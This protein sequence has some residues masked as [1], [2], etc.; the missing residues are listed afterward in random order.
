M[1][2]NNGDGRL[3]AGTRTEERPHPS[4]G[5][6]PYGDDMREQ[7]IEMWLDGGM[8][9]LNAPHLL[10]LRHAKKFPSLPKCKRWIEQ[11]QEEG[12]VRPK[13]ATGNHIA[14]REIE[15]IDLF[16]LGIY[17]QVRPKAYIDEVRAF[18]HNM[19][20]TV[21]PYS[22]SQVVRAEQRLGLS[23]KAASTTSECA[24]IPINLT[25]RVIYWEDPI[26]GVYGVPKEDMIDIDECCLNLQSTNREW[27]KVV[28]EVRCDA[29][30]HYK[31]GEGKISLLHAIGG[32]DNAPISF[33]K[34]YTEGGT[35]LWRFY[36]F[37]EEFIEYLNQHFPGRSFCFTMD[38]LNVHKNPM[39]MNLIRGAG[40]RLVFRA[41]YWSCDG[42]IE[43]VFNTIQTMLQMDYNAIKTIEE[44]QNAINVV[45]GNL[46]PFGR[47]FEHV[48]F[49]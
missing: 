44:L 49:P 6:N 23:R 28:R 12:N 10:P 45:I 31:R 7:V 14:E 2:N 36:C 32:D 13:R 1:S 20:P 42:A 30:G 34:Q 3:V 27:G 43:Y 38:N 21:D 18:I 15:G 26:D 48:G 25:K 17:R 29:T 46:A 22:P 4:N 11:Y 39:V 8:E 37:I 5:G 35:D 40:H 33:H 24:Y 16:H 9:A 19:N 47:Y 41:P